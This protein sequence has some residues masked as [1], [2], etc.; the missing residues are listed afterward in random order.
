M[1]TL[2][3]KYNDRVKVL[4]NFPAVLQDT[5]KGKKLSEAERVVV[6]D[7][8]KKALQVNDTAISVQDLR[9]QNPKAR[10]ITKKGRKKAI[11]PSKLSTAKIYQIT[12]DFPVRFNTN[13]SENE[14]H[15]DKVNDLKFEGIL[16]KVMQDNRHMVSLSDLKAKGDKYIA[17]INAA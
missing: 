10:D 6:L 2:A 13:I 7:M 5:L 14:K 8:F 11:Q 3:P 17:S 4:Q 1:A 16:T 15:A 9:L 12:Q